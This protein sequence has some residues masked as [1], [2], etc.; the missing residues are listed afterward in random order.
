MAAMPCGVNTERLGT[1][2]AERNGGRSGRP[3]TACA[4]GC[5]GVSVCRA[6]VS[7]RVHSA[8][9]AATLAAGSR[10]HKAF[11]ASCRH[12]GCGAC[13]SGAVVAMDLRS[14]SVEGVGK[15]VGRAGVCMR[16]AAPQ[17]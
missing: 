8:C 11:R 16:G 15:G 9:T 4:N 17:G 12:S 2:L 3:G 13:A 5:R 14:G 7:M 10:R 6:K 1:A